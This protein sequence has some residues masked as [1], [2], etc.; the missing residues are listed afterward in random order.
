MKGNCS[1]GA[2]HME[3]KDFPG[4]ESHPATGAGQLTRK[5]KCYQFLSEYQ[6]LILPDQDALNLFCMD[7]VVYLS[8]RWNLMVNYAREPRYLHIKSSYFRLIEDGISQPGILHYSGYRKSLKSNY[9]NY[10][11]IFWRYAVR[12]PRF[13]K[14]FRA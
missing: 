12:S 4:G 10:D 1:P 13:T 5:E 8:I 6:D 11:S 3:S 9:L 14:M 2:E 7:K